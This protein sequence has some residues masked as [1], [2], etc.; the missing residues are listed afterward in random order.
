MTLLRF[1][2]GALLVLPFLLYRGRLHDLDGLGWR[3][4]VGLALA[5]GPLFGLV[6]YSAF[7]LAPLAHATV[8]PPACVMV[9]G[10]ALSALLLGERPGRYQLAGCALLALGLLAL[11]YDGLAGGGR[12]T[13]LG[14]L[15]FALAGCSWGVFTFLLRRWRVAPAARGGGG[16]RPVRAR[17]RAGVAPGHG[18]RPAAGA[19]PGPSWRS[20]SSRGRWGACWGWP[21]SAGRCGRSGRRRPRRCRRSRP[22]PPRW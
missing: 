7:A 9:T 8:F 20:G 4:G 17:H 21:R 13:W 1:A 14:D 18:R 3:R 15:L 22:R 11:A 2:G 16:D 19:R 10:M 6:V 12:L 5:G